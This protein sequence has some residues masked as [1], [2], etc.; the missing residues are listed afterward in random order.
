MPAPTVAA[1]LAAGGGS[2]FDP[3]QHK[4]LAPLRGQPVWQWALQAMLAAGFDRVVVVTGAVGL[5]VPSPAVEYHNPRWQEGQATSLRTA[6]AAAQQL[7]ATA[8]TI[9]L[10]DQPFIPTATWQAVA[11]APAHHRIVI[12][13]YDGKPGPNPVRLAEEVWPLLPTSGD[14]G[15][16][17]VIRAHPEWVSTVACLGSTADIDTLEDLDRW[18][19]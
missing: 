3:V 18:N 16:R 19:R 17:D 8:V 9:G 12:A 1:L 2:R 6:V 7:G 11:H 15:A 14:L 13:T 5:E 4:L 10:A